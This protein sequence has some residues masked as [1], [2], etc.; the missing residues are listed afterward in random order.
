MRDVDDAPGWQD[1]SELA[2]RLLALPESKERIE[3]SLEDKQ[4]CKMIEKGLEIDYYNRIRG[5]SYKVYEHVLEE[6]L[7]GIIAADA[8]PFLWS[9]IPE[10]L[11]LEELQLIKAAINCKTEHASWRNVGYLYR[12]NPK[13]W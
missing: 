1:I 12:S 10:G 4:F 3:R 11:T 13:Q 6:I 5:T 2:E 9:L 7:K 8:A